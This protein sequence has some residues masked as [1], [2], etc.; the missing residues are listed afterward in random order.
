MNSRVSG[1]CSYTTLYLTG[2]L[3]ISTHTTAYILNTGRDLFVL[4]HMY[5]TV[6]SKFKGM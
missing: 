3:H 1:Q 4:F 5:L 6:I 2:I